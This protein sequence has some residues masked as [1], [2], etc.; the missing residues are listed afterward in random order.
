M[1]AAG[2]RRTQTCPSKSGKRSS[3]SSWRPGGRSKLRCVTAKKLRLLLPGREC[4]TP[5]SRWG[6]GADRGG[7]L[8]H[9]PI[10]RHAER[11]QFV[12]FRETQASMAPTLLVS[13]RAMSRARDAAKAVLD[14]S[15]PVGFV[16]RLREMPVIKRILRILDRLL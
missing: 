10:S 3:T 12:L 9:R 6:S 16:E 8:R 4:R 7:N 1:V 5:K 11:H 15:N 13:L 2:V 14:E